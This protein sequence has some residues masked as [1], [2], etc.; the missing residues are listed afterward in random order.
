M[1]N[2]PS[3]SG[4]SGDCAWEYAEFYYT[5]V[6]MMYILHVYGVEG[7][8]IC[9]IRCDPAKGD[10][11]IDDAR[12]RT[13]AEMGADGWELVNI[14]KTEGN[15]MQGLQGHENLTLY[16]KRVIAPEE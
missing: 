3:S 13:I 1:F 8:E 9:E 2:M 12:N 4:L 7:G 16:F 6:D 10:A 11:T 14:I 5:T 15:F